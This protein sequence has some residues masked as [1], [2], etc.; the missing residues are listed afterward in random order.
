MANGLCHCWDLGEQVTKGRVMARLL[1][2]HG[3]SYEEAKL[4]SGDVWAPNPVFTSVP[5]DEIVSVGEELVDL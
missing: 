2:K 1:E 3:D 5:F 4:V